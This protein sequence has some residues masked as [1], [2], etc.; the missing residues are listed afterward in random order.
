MDLMTHSS[1]FLLPTIPADNRE[2]STYVLVAL[3]QRLPTFTPLLWMHAQLRI[4][5]DGGANRLYDEMP[6]FFPLEDALDVRHRYKPDIIKGDMDSIRAEVLE[7]YMS[8]VI[9]FCELLF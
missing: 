8:L 3:N 4:C 7:F 1:V 6:L 5:A 2:S 9:N